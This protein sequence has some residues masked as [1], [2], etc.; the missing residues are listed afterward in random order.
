MRWERMLTD[1]GPTRILDFGKY[2]SRILLVHCFSDQV[3]YRIKHKTPE[4]RQGNVYLGA[5]QLLQHC[6]DVGLISTALSE[7]WVDGH[8]LVILAERGPKPASYSRMVHFN[9]VSI[10]KAVCI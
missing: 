2:I 1:S 4:F 3:N 6:Y 7:Q 5:K 10:A 8:C 9:T